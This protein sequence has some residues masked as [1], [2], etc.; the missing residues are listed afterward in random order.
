MTRV[1]FVTARLAM[2]VV[3]VCLVLFCAVQGLAR[4]TWGLS[5]PGAAIE[6]AGMDDVAP[7]WLRYEPK[8][9]HT[10]AEW[11]ADQ[12]RAFHESPMWQART[13]SGEL[14]PVEQRLPQNPLVIVPGDQC[15]PYGGT[16]RRYATGPG[17]IGITPSRLCYDGIIRFGPMGT[18][19]LPNLAT[20]WTVSEDARTT[21]FY[22]RKGVRWSDGAP[23]TADDVLFWYEDVLLNPDL[24]ATVPLQ[25][26]RGG[27][28]MRIE[29]VD[30][31]TF[32]CC[33]KEPYGLFVKVL[34]QG[35]SDQML[36]CPAHYLKQFLPKYTDQAVLEEMAR[37]RRF[38]FWYQVF[39]DQHDWDNP[40]HPRLWAWTI[41]DPPPARPVIWE[42]NPYYWK[43][44]PEGNQLPYIDRI[45]YEIYDGETINLKCMNGEV[46]MQ[47]RHLDFAS[48]P[49]FMENQERGGY[50]LL[51]WI[52]G[53]DGANPVALNLNH[54]DPVMREIFGDKRFR[55]ALSHAINRDELNQACYFGLGKPRQMC[56]P[57]TSPYYFEEYETAH[58]AYDPD[59]ANRL[60]DE[61]GLNQ[62]DKHGV[63]LRPDGKPLRIDIEVSSAML[64]PRLIQLVAEYWTAVG[65]E[66]EMKLLAR[67]LTTARRNALM[68]DATVW[69]GAGEFIPTLD[70][71]WFFPH[72]VGS[73]HAM[74]YF[75]WY[76]SDGKRGER[77]T[78][79]MIRCMEIYDKIEASAD[80][81]EQIALFKD[82]M[83][84]NAENLW[85]IGL[86]GEMPTI[87]VVKNTFRNV[88]EVAVASWV[89]RTPGAT[90]CECYAIEE[91]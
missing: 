1:V 62:R 75:R 28:V 87:S 53:G 19:V 35:L 82:I 2:S 39:W 90:A 11:P 73:F 5:S 30:D 64:Y 49:L 63:R 45:S 15:G 32:R 72:N 43:V 50:R 55:I 16:W 81:A 69:T 84:I 9:L 17:D 74:A 36:S 48:Y 7:A 71:R 22:L 58:I 91:D 70:P 40:E 6:A 12:P 80:D 61:M 21:T 18:K 38:D 33:F 67:Q 42:R 88:P 20:H 23:F 37:K 10:V 29:K 51:H 79:E 59:R 46:G 66:T 83:R 24:T 77:P 57:T 8:T 76:V 13:A 3:A 14:E 78:P 60:L 44:D 56:P 68:Q 41:K 34:A 86:V 26:K 52:D 54:R 47:G 89:L 31:Y 25:F 65:V 27:E 85:V 4:L